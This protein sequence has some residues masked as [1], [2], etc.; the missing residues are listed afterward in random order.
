M[1]FVA[2]VALVIVLLTSMALAADVA[3]LKNGFTIRHERRQV[4]GAVTRLYLPGGGYVDVPSD[5]IEEI[6][7]EEVEPAVAVT[8]SAPAKPAAKKVDV[9]QIVFDASMQEQIDPDFIASVVKAESSWNARAVSAKG[10][11]GLMQLMPGTADQLG[12]KDPFDPEQNV[13]GGVTY[14][15]QLLEQYNGDAVK[16]LAAYN[17]G[18]QRVAQYRGVP[19]YHETQAYVAA[20]VRDYNRK[21]LAQKKAAA[22]ASAFPT[23]RHAISNWRLAGPARAVLAKR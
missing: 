20:I 21:K 12:V 14:L 1:R 9:H 5:E 2:K 19:P 6:Q 3:V 7:T 4:I 22:R 17:A 16:A 15:R 8:P 23:T 10:A 13:N 18:P 11:R